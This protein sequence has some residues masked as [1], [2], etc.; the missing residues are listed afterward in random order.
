M[1]HSEGCGCPHIHGVKCEV[2]N[3]VYNNQKEYC[4]AKEIKVGPSYASSSTDTI[5][6][7]FKPE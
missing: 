1:N 7:T 4:T 5:C 3:C 2:T 6:A